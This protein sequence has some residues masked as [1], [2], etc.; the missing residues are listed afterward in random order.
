MADLMPSIV[1]TEFL[2]VSHRK[3][4]YTVLPLPRKLARHAVQVGVSGVRV[5]LPIAGT[6]GG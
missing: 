3:F 1:L 6:L 5:H 2:T 4:E